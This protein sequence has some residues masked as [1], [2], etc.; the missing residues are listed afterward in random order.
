MVRNEGAWRVDSKT[1]II[2]TAV[3]TA[4]NVADSTVLPDL[5][6]GEETRVWGDQGY[7]GQTEVIK[8]CAPLAQDQTHR[9]YRKRGRRRRTGEE[10]GEIECAVESGARVSGDENQI[11]IRKAALSR[12]QEEC[13][14]VLCDLWPG[15]SVSQP[16]KADVGNERVDGWRDARWFA[17][18]NQVA[19]RASEAPPFA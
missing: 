6:H 18:A 1:K 9:R 14:P 4:A 2:H 15:Q 19:M 16:E 12:T 13:A 17:K 7:R 8:E 5:Q 11:R 3:A 10:P